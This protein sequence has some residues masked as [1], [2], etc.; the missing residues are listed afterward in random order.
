MNKKSKLLSM[1]LVLTIVCSLFLPTVYAKPKTKIGINSKKISLE[2]GEEYQLS[3]SGTVNNINWVTANEDVAIVDDDGLVTAVGTGKTK[4][5]AKVKGKKYSCQVTVKQSAY[6]TI[7]LQNDVYARN[8]IQF[9]YK[10]LDPISIDESDDTIEIVAYVDNYNDFIEKCKSD[11]DELL[12]KYQ[13]DDVVIMPSEDYMSYSASC[14]F[15][16]SSE[17]RY[18]FPKHYASEYSRKAVLSLIFREVFC[19]AYLTGNTIDDVSITFTDTDTGNTYTNYLNE[20]SGFIHY[21][22]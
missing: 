13:T 7:V 10:G 16:L 18:T 2:V 17:E 19:I 21:D 15:N 8:F 1:V 14:S 4:V 5:T 3:L 9:S 11:I 12:V 22:W 6:T 20:I